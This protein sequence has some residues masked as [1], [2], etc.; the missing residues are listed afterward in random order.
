MS[1]RRAAAAAEILKPFAALNVDDDISKHGKSRNI[2]AL[3]FA[4]FT[5]SGDSTSH[6]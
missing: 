6:I 5:A 4:E 2:G 3:F 1:C